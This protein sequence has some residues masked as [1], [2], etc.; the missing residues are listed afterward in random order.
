MQETAATAAAK[1]EFLPEIDAGILEFVQKSGKACAEDVMA[2]FHYKGS[3]AA[4][5]RLNAWRGTGC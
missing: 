5:S 2:Q 1:V 3:N 4:S